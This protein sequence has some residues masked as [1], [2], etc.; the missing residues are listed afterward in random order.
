MQEE[1]AIKLVALVVA[2]LLAV[3]WAEWLSAF[4]MLDACLDA[5][6]VY[7]SATGACMVQD[8]AYA[9]PFARPD[10]YLLWLFFLSAVTAPAIGL[11]YLVV[12]FVDRI[13]RTRP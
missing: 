6:G 5:G 3:L 10:R 9:G 12:R 8:G 2:V 7:D 13:L 4:L 11:Y 1:Q